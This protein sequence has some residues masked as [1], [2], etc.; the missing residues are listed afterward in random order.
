[1]K[2]KISNKAITIGYEN[3]CPKCKKLM[4]R[5]KHPAHWVNKNPVCFYTEWDYCPDC[6]HVQH[7]EEYK[8]SS[9]KELDRQR[10]F[11]NSI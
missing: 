3:E 11:L 7:Y 10:S 4:E 6:N 9:W 1:M 2:N 5:R 8:S